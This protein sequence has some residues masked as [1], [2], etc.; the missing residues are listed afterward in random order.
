MLQA[1]LGGQCSLWAMRPNAGVPDRVLGP[2]PVMDR[3]I[4]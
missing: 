1:T 4:N 3:L 2:D